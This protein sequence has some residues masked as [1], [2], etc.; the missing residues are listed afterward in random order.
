[1]T[2]IAAYDQKTCDYPILQ[3]DHY[4]KL[5]QLALKYK[6]CG[7]SDQCMHEF[8]QVLDRYLL[9]PYR[10]DITMYRCTV[11]RNQSDNKMMVLSLMFL[12][13][14]F[15]LDNDT[16]TI[17]AKIIIDPKCRALAQG[18]NDNLDTID[19]DF[20]YIDCMTTTREFVKMQ[21][22]YIEKLRIVQDDADTFKELLAFEK[23]DLRDSIDAEYAYSR[24]IEKLSTDMQ[25]FKDLYND[26]LASNE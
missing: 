18:L 12:L 24:K 11:K 10:K 2:F 20:T 8:L 22:M 9:S 4:C 26:L 1:M 19:G 14:M 3:N 15:V 21:N 7:Q 23:R 25:M 13:R 6:Q 17:S 5:S 16:D